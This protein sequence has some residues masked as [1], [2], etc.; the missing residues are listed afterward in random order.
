MMKAICW[1]KAPY[2]S[3]SHWSLSTPVMSTDMS[4]V[5]VALFPS[6]EHFFIYIQVTDVL[7][8]KLIPLI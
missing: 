2:I 4:Q 1:L 3:S 8:Y 6:F 7:C 5:G